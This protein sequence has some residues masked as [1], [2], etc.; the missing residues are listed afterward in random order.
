MKLILFL[1]G[2]FSISSHSFAV[3]DLALSAGNDI[4]YDSELKEVS[5]DCKTYTVKFKHKGTLPD[6]AMGHNVVVAEEKNIKKILHLMAKNKDQGDLN[7][8]SSLVI[9][10][11]KILGGKQSGNFSFTIEEEQKNNIELAYFCSFPG[12]SKYMRGKIVL[13]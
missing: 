9:G 7:F 2:L 13:K 1:A 8:E 10:K 5:K 12:H 3:C 6:Y 11:T 4:S